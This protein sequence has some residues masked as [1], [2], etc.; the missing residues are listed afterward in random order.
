M[1]RNADSKH[2][3]HRHDYEQVDPNCGMTPFGSTPSH[4]QGLP[5]DV[6]P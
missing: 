4:T 3:S 2:E 1:E 6:S 5:L